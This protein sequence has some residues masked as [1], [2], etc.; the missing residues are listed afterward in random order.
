VEAEALDVGGEEQL[1]I[2]LPILSLRV[3]EEE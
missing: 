1:P 2:F 3:Q